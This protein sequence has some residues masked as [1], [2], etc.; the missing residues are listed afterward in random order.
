MSC[1]ILFQK[2][3][4]KTKID[5]NN[6]MEYRIN[7]KPCLSYLGDADGT[8]PA[9]ICKKSSHEIAVQ[10]QTLRLR[11][12]CERNIISALNIDIFNATLNGGAACEVHLK[13]I[14]ETDTLAARITCEFTEVLVRYDCGQPYS[15]IHHCEDCKVI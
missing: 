15:L 10:L 5:D 9:T 14:E 8:S 7:D 13:Q 2:K 11:H 12:C 1:N 4:K 6:N 3:N